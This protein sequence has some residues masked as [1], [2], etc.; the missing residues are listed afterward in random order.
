MI[1]INKIAQ[2][3]RL[4]LTEHEVRTFEPQ[5]NAIF[6]YFEELSSVPTANVEP[7]ITPSDIE[8]VLRADKKEQVQTVE[9]SLKNAPERSGNLFKVPPVV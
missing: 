5:L 9:E 2:L 4:S 3:A 1:E 7:L 6:K 8:V